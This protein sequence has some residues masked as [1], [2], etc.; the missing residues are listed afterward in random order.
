[1][2]QQTVYSELVSQ[3]ELARLNPKL[4]EP[5]GV[6]QLKDFHLKKPEMYETH[7][8]DKIFFIGQN[9]L[10]GTDATTEQ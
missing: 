8:K 3:D 1:V 10:Q 6:K 2:T 7:V 9:A 4:T 5:L